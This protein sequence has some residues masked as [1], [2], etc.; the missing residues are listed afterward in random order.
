M[1]INWRKRGRAVKAFFSSQIDTVHIH[2]QG[3]SFAAHELSRGPVRGWCCTEQCQIV[4]ADSRH[5]PTF[6]SEEFQIN[7]LLHTLGGTIG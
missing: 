5:R 7:S 1:K 3:V 6:W 2:I 4:R